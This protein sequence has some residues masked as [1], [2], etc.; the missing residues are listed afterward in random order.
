MKL[1]VALCLVGF[2]YAVV[3]KIPMERIKSIREQL[4]QKVKNK[5]S[6]LIGKNH[7]E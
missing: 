7:E 5:H 3:V 6:L 1:L 4:I 2:S